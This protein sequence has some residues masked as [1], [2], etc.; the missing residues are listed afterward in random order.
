M[1]DTW[2]KTENRTNAGKEVFFW[3]AYLLIALCSFAFMIVYGAA[4]SFWYDEFAQISFSGLKMSVIDSALV[5]DPTP[6]LFNVLAN[7]WYHAI[8]YGDRWLL[9]L[10]QIA[11]TAAVFLAGVWGE[12]MGGRVVGLWTALFLGF[13]QM[14]M[15]QCGFE[16]RGY[17]FLLFF[18]TASFLLHDRRTAAG[19]GHALLYALVLAGLLYSHLFGSLIAFAFGLWDLA[20]VLKRKAPVLSLLPYFLALVSFLPWI[21][22]FL[23][24][25]A[26]EASATPSIW[27]VK[28]SVW[29]VIKLGAYLCGNH[30]VLCAL[31]LLGA[32]TVCL[33]AVEAKKKG[34]LSAADKER[35]LPLFSMVLSVALVFVYGVTRKDYAS[36]WE[37]RYFTELFPCA[38]LFCGFGAESLIKEAGKRFHGK[39][40]T[41]AA[42]TAVCLFVATIP[43]FLFKTAKQDTPLAV[44]HHREAAAQLL[45]QPD[46]GDDS[47]LV[48]S[49]LDVFTEAWNVY[50][51]G[52][53]QE[54]AFRARGIGEMSPEDLD[55]F[56]VIYYEYGFW[57]EN[58]EKNAAVQAMR[59]QFKLDTVWEDCQLARFVRQESET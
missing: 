33:K 48:L 21:V 52:R 15:E 17:A 47:V 9:L 14:V 50:Y 12:S 53:G 2:K 28:P 5:L 39:K 18:S 6:P 40:Q 1:A 11:M 58:A 46:I 7:I 24:H 31:L 51:G 3:Q 36:L 59:K 43:V 37:K 29:E 49:T 54:E 34:E 44:Y 23:I 16:F 30:I 25:V 19:K 38:A 32:I 42:I 41:A 20:S 55:D 13:S 10:P 35:L 45:S 8:P 27:M 56:D 22:F 57:P 26:E 4:G